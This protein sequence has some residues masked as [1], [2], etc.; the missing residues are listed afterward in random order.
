LHHLKTK[1][2]KQLRSVVETMVRMLGVV[3]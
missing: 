3:H 1:E 2:I